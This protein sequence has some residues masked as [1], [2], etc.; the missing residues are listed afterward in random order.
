MTKQIDVTV[1][2]PTYYGEKYLDELLWMVFKQKVNF[3][4]EV[5][6]Y[7]TSSKDETPTIIDKY[8]KLHTNLRHKTITKE[9]FGHGKTR[10]S[11]A[12][13]ARGDIIVYLSQDA[14]PAHDRWLYEMVQPFTLNDRVVGVVG[15]Q[16]PRP[17]ALPLLKS[18]I[19]AVFNN[20]GNDRGTTLYYHDDF[21]KDQAQYDQVCFYSDVNSAARKSVLLGDVPY[22]DVPYAEDQ[23][24]GRDLINAGYIKA[25][26]PRGNVL[27][28]NDI[29]LADYKHRMF[30]ET[31]GLKKIGIP[32]D[33]PSIRLIVKMVIKG[34]IKDTWRTINDGQY[35]L[36]R[37]L[38]WLLLN[39][40]YHVEKWRGVRLAAKTRVDDTNAVEKYSLESLQKR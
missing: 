40:L 20:L 31:M 34:S 9:E 30:D 37:K 8:A 29:E 23:M 38:Y 28:T 7:D 24:F 17:K 39:P 4:Y 25:Y 11:V 15:K 13:D 27:H 22:R 12:R 21:I 32:I 3:T 10:Q 36:K 14:T 16:D 35:S 26:A 19:R 6:I 33:T 1:F 2:I 5:L 18:E